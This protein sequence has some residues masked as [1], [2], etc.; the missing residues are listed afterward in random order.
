MGTGP[1]GGTP[2]RRAARSA[3]AE[4]SE[5]RETRR[6]TDRSRGEKHAAERAQLASSR[7]QARNNKRNHNEEARTINE[8][9]DEGARGAAPSPLNMPAR[10]LPPMF[11]TGAGL[12][13][14]FTPGP[15]YRRPNTAH[16]PM[17]ARDER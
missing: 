6:K 17:A 16:H 8:E 15:G 9:G 3:D 10:P 2:T 11:R 14:F 13:G 4:R 7:P 5:A 1:G 12:F